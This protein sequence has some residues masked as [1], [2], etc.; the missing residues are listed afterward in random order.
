MKTKI[1][2]V[3]LLLAGSVVFAQKREIRDAEKA[4]ENGQFSEAQTLLK[5]VE[6]NIAGEKDRIKED[7]YM[8]KGKAYMGKQPQSQSMENMMIA[9]E[10][11]KMA[12]D[13]GNEDAGAELGK[14]RES[15]INSAIMDQKSKKYEAASQKLITSYNLNKN[16]TIHLYYAASNATQG[17]DYATAL[18]YY[19]MLSDLGYVG[20]TT[21]YYAINKGTQE[22]ERFSDKKQ[23][24][25]YIKSGDYSSPSQETLP[26][27]NAEITKNIALIYIQQGEKDKA[28]EAIES[29]KAANP[30]DASL[31]L[32][33]ADIYY[34]AGNV[35]KY[36]E[37]VEKV[38]E[39]DPTNADL[40][41]NLGVTAMQ[42]D[43]PEKA[44]K[45]YKSAIEVNPKMTNAYINLANTILSKEKT[46]ID[47]MNGLG[48][49]KAD[50]KRYDELQKERSEIYEQGLPY[51]EKAVDIEPNNKEAIQTLVNIHGILGNEEK[52]AK[53]K[54]M[55][56]E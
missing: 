39:Q 6:S 38:I 1:L 55:L 40:Y 7:F 27:K 50:T 12:K 43:A 26:P 4:I 48:M 20:S 21:E 37:I 53:F 24:D 2:A 18:K 52:A 34:K 25:F 51:L 8:A 31:M 32:A 45:Y 23:R 29:A 28:M 47:E 10:S 41:Y 22:K 44:I 11:F 56:K 16:D 9:G 42:M 46:I 14:L 15:L 54:A 33:E 5:S 17:K 13:L 3:S 36:S 49:S 19:E 30:G 35:E